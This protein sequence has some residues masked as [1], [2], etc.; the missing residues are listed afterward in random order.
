MSVRVAA[1]FED[2]IVRILQ[3]I[4]IQKGQAIQTASLLLHPK[5]LSELSLLCSISLSSKSD[6]F[7]QVPGDAL[8]ELIEH[9][10]QRVLHGN[11]MR[12]LDDVVAFLSSA[13]LSSPSAK[14]HAV[15][16]VRQFLLLVA[17]V[18]VVVVV[19]RARGYPRVIEKTNIKL[20][21]VALFKCQRSI[22]P[23]IFQYYSFFC[24]LH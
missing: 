3:R 13:E 19:V 2:V 5:E 1:S 6:G 9:L 18:L 21:I 16:T 17:P 20:S 15:E 8:V 24:F 22:T 11:R 23:I 10:R 12:I 4:A 7:H 14:V